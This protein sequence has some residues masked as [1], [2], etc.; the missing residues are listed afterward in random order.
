MRLSE[1]KPCAMCKGALRR[2]PAAQWYVLRMSHAMLNPQTA[3]RVLG[4]TQFF[5]GGLGLAEAFETEKPVVIL[6]D[7]E[8]ELMHEVHICFDCWTS[9]AFDGMRD[10]FGDM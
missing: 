3:N 10:L 9:K 8:K 2:P 7:C 1:L 4:L 6:G 5:Q